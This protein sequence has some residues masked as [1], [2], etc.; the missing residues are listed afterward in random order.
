LLADV[1]VPLSARDCDVGRRCAPLADV[2][3][4]LSA[5]NCEVGRPADHSLRLERKK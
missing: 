1:D 2:D 3:V 4:P 5:R